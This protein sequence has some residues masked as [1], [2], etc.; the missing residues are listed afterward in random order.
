MIRGPSIPLLLLLLIPYILGIASQI[1]LN[2]MESPL[3]TTTS[4]HP[5][6]PAMPVQVVSPAADV[7]I[8]ESAP[9]INYGRDPNL[10]VG[11]YCADVGELKCMDKN[12]E[13]LIVFSESIIVP[14]GYTLSSA[15]L[16]LYVSKIPSGI[17][18]DTYLILA[19]YPLT[20]IPVPESSTTWRTHGNFDKINLDEI[21]SVMDLKTI[22]Y[23]ERGLERARELGYADAIIS[24]YN[25]YSDGV[26]VREG[27]F[28][29]FDVTPYIRQIIKMASYQGFLIKMVQG[30]VY[31]YVGPPHNNIAFYSKDSSPP[32]L[33]W[34]PSLRITYAPLFSLSV[35][36]NFEQIAQGGTAKFAVSI[37]RASGFSGD[38][39]L[40]V[41]PPPP[42]SRVEFIHE[43][44]EIV[45]ITTSSSTPPGD[46]SIY[47]EGS[48][49]GLT[50]RTYVTL[51][52]LKL[53]A[54][55]KLITIPIPILTRT[56][57]ITGTESTTI[58]T[59]IPTTLITI[60]PPNTAGTVSTATGS[61]AGPGTTRREPTFIMD[62]LDTP[63]TLRVGEQSSFRITISSFY[64]FSDDVTLTASNLPQGV[65]ITSDTNRV[66]PN[67]TVKMTLSAS[68]SASPGTYT[69]TI[70]ASGGGLMRSSTFSLNVLEASKTQGATSMTQSTS[71]NQIVSGGRDFLIKVFPENLSINTGSS[72]SVAVTVS[73]LQ[74]NGTV[75]LNVTGLPPDARAEFNPPSLKEGT[76]SLVIRAGSTQGTFTVIVT[77]SS[78]GITR[79][80]T[81][82][83]QI[84][85]G[86][87][88]CFIATA[89]YGSE[90]SPQVSFL[91]NF[92]DEV[93]MSTYSGSRFLFAFNIFYYSWSPKVA[94]MVRS[95]P[96]IAELTRYSLSPLLA[97]LS[98]GTEVQK[99]GH[100]ELP[101]I[102]MGI[103]VSM[104]LGSIYLAPLSLI[105]QLLH[106]PLSK[107]VPKAVI[108]MMIA[109]I[110][111]LLLGLYAYSDIITM[112]FSSLLVVSSLLLIPCCLLTID[113][114]GL[115]KYLL[116]KSP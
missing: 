81:F 8:N 75:G 68:S 40:G 19:V 48:G 27:S 11:T 105:I 32:R 98:L 71:A 99:L 55:T 60:R 97:T 112:I 37:N 4:A 13:T 52:V 9:D 3:S 28:I 16:R 5:T 86:E 15:K 90:L 88:R 103:I 59:A 42:G 65:S 93:V 20:L 72:G 61:T 47:I 31:S 106:K 70:I 115:I 39:V 35:S 66:P 114:R 85:G 57:P 51:R 83:L 46:Y 104:I 45:M 82:Q 18:D 41:G 107:K 101:I 76:S 10:F 79:S 92:R 87:S 54:P 102:M 96:L 53:L 6:V 89:A 95:N 64:G 33:D 23:S 14:S 77:G 38:V 56:R 44:P 100:G 91:R 2:S 50:Y 113:L 12:L 29:E 110:L 21:N 49:G 34:Y 25:I 116:G 30:D 73:W 58:T 1:D 22:V 69:V 108:L 78:G 62:V 24:P 43:T 63:V 111:Y 67:S 109:S 36:P 7:T 84:T 17:S 74:G 80:S 26:V 94:E